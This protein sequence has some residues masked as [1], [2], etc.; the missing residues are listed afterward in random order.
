[1]VCQLSARDS[2]WDAGRLHSRVRGWHLE[3]DA[4]RHRGRTAIIPQPP[5][6]RTAARTTGFEIMIIQPAARQRCF[7]AI[8]ACAVMAMIGSAAKSAS[9][10]SCG[11]P[12]TRSS[13]HLKG[14]QHTARTGGGCGPFDRI[15]TAS[16]PLKR[17]SPSRRRIRS[18]STAICWLISL[19]SVAVY[20]RR[21]GGRGR[22]PD[23]LITP[24]PV[25][26]VRSCR[27]QR[28][29]QRIHDR[30]LGDGLGRGSRLECHIRLSLLPQFL[31]SERVGRETS[32]VPGE[33]ETPNEVGSVNLD[34][35][36]V[37]NPSAPRSLN[38]ALQPKHDP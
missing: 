30:G 32:A 2:P 10:R 13:R 26:T 17:L 35:G 27:L 34:D 5:R 8:V 19:S 29:S 20:E 12:D 24:P 33:G 28:R 11:R 3:T 7:S 25:V 36:V 16:R 37:Y 9:E 23:H 38:A 6:F 14:H 21:A 4:D 18:N 22:E 31:A 15:S 1:V